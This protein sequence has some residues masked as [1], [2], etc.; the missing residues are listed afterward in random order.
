M[1]AL[2]VAFLGLGNMGTP[3]AQHVHKAG[4]LLRVYNRSPAKA[5]PFRD[6]GVLVCPTPKVA[7]QA[8]DVVITML[9]DA[10]AVEEVLFGPEGVAASGKRDLVV[11]DMSTIAPAQAQALAQRARSVGWRML[12]APVS[13]SVKAAQDANLV[14]LAGGER[15]AFEQC[16][17]VFQA[18]S[19]KAYYLGSPGMGA[20]MK[21]ALQV[22]LTLLLEG[23]AEFLAFA[24]RAGL[25]PR[26]AIEILN[27][28]TSNRSGL[29]EARGPL[30]ARGEYPPTF[31]ISLMVKDL[32]LVAETASELGIPLPALAVVRELY[33]A[34]DARGWGDQD[35]TTIT[36]L[37][38]ELT[39][40]GGPPAGRAAL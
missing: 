7:A 34:A 38:Q 15:E 2:E 32:G 21:L 18:L 20:T 25:D 31:A 24:R 26:L 11:A 1:A 16:L 4:F 30:L 40:S 19:R 14:V 35:F 5:E 9:A 39:D 17:P 10:R 23:L 28:T 36:R 29:S 6:L 22:N 8:A 37:L 3:M 33:A 13:G 27:A 12:D